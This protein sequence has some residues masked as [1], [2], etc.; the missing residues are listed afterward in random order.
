MCHLD[1]VLM[2]ASTQ[3]EHDA[4]LHAALAKIQ[5]AGLTLNEEKCEFNKERV[6]FLGHVVD[7]NGISAD[8]QKISAILELKKPNSC[9]ELQRF[10][11]MVNQLSKFSPH[12]AEVS[13]PPHEHLSIRSHGCRDQLRMMHMT[14]SNRSWQNLQSWHCMTHRP[15][16]RFVLM[17]QPM[18]WEQCFSSNT[19]TC[20]GSQLHMQSVH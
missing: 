3:Q 9:T 13:K 7:K 17:L 1:D 11:G 16:P 12:I 14:R 4:R 10:M 20:T 6:T 19:L 2:F 18:V 5:A 15:A 8:P